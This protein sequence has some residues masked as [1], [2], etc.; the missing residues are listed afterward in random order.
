MAQVAAAV[1]PEEVHGPSRAEPGSPLWAGM[2]GNQELLN[3]RFPIVSRIYRDVLGME[4]IDVRDRAVATSRAVY[5]CRAPPLHP[6]LW[7]LGRDAVFSLPAPE[8]LHRR[9]K[10]VYC[11][12]RDSKTTE[13]PGRLLVNEPA[14]VALLQARC[15]AAATC[16]E[17]V[18]FNH[19]N[20]NNSV[21][22]IA[23]FFA[24]AIGLVSP[25]GGCLTNVNF[26]PCNA[27][28]VEIMPLAGG[29]WGAPTEPH[30]HMLYIQSVFL[31][32][33]YYM[34]PV[35]S[36]PATVDDMDVPLDELGDVL[37]EILAPAP[38]V[39]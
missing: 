14:V 29:V 28:V 12:R 10:L 20:F 38:S 25:H 11:S 35:P 13:H 8:P 1:L 30:W 34:L 9:R 5:A 16:D 18:T 31:E 27:G 2:V 6:F 37:D 4:P 15:E 24:D 19:R 32:H 17:V 36:A 21:S 33:R 23:A 26:L 22:A 39:Q 7:Q 3:D